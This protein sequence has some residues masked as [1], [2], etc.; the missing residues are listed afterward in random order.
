MGNWIVVGHVGYY[1]TWKRDSSQKTSCESNK[2][3]NLIYDELNNKE[4][5]QFLNEIMYSEA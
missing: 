2:T 3:L 5:G 1:N 4:W